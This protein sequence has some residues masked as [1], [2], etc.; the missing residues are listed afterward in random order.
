MANSTTQTHRILLLA[1][2]GLLL[3]VQGCRKS[4]EVPKSGSP[5]LATIGGVT[6]T[7]E[8]LVAEAERRRLKN[9]PV[10]GKEELLKAMVSRS[11]L[12]LNA[13]GSGLDRDPEIRRAMDAVLL[14]EMR[15]RGLKE[16]ID[17]IDISEEELRAAYDAEAANYFQAAKARLSILH[18][19][20]GKS[21]SESKRTE[22]RSRLESAREQIIANPPRGGRGPAAQGFGALAIE[23]SDDQVSR[24]KGGDAGWF[25]Q[26]ENGTR[27]P[28]VVLDAGHAL[29]PGELSQ[30]LESEGDF[31]LVTKTS[32]RPASTTPFEQAE[33]G[34]RLTL[35]AEKRM[36]VENA[37]NEENERLAGVE[38]NPAALAEV[39]LHTVPA[40]GEPTPP[41]LP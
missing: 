11:A 25:E 8:D 30:V 6:I 4:E 35:L 14:G 17:A 13:K 22:L 34:L 9:Q 21:P 32:E 24:Y 33:S 38:M 10:P 36:A 15:E 39:E 31:Y 29:K 20:G 41:S 19:I 12:I 27:W 37:F 5:I 16:R 3:G 40:K 2:V 26:G 18:L 28:S 1:T 7:V 23:N